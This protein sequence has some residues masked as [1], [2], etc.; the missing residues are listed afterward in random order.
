MANDK[1]KL[2]TIL[3]KQSSGKIP[4]KTKYQIEDTKE[5]IVL[6]KEEGYPKGKFIFENGEEFDVQL[7]YNSV[8]IELKKEYTEPYYNEEVWNEFDKSLQPEKIIEEEQ[9]KKEN[10]TNLK[11]PI[12]VISILL[13]IFTIIITA[14]LLKKNKSKISNNKENML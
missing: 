9:P 4:Y 2:I 14:I 10:Q 7:H 5:I 8:F 3:Q 11:L 13:M 6:K 1:L 12:I